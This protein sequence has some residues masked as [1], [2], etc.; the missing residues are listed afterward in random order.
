MNKTI[1]TLLTSFKYIYLIIFFT[2]LAGVFYPLITM[3]PYTDTV[4]G[5]L[6]LLLGLVGGIL[7]YKAATSYN[8]RTI[9]LGSGFALLGLS[10]FL[11]FNLTGRT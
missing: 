2:L 1:S 7:L 10:L 3:T 4:S 5:V 8:K 6:V 9:F 11:V